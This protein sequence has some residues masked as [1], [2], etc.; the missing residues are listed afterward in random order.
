SALLSEALDAGLPVLAT[1]GSTETCSQVA[2][3]APGEQAEAMGTAGR[4]LE[5]FEVRVGDDGRIEVRGP[6]VATEVLEGPFRGEDEWLQ[7]G[8][9]GRWDGSGRLVIEGRADRVI[10]TGGVNVHPESVESALSRHPAIADVHVSGV[11][12]SDWGTAVTAEVVV[13]TGARFDEAAVAA[14]ARARLS[15]PQVPKRWLVVDHIDR[16]ELGKHRA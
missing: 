9:L 7:M 10:V 12:D 8:D 5:G 11:P 16:T 14:W 6:A 15:G 1:Y 2:T 3:V 4:A 13:A